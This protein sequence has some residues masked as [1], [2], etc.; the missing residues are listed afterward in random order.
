M[1]GISSFTSRPIRHHV[2][3]IEA[4]GL[5][6][7]ASKGWKGYSHNIVTFSH[8]FTKPHII[9][10]GEIHPGCF[11]SQQALFRSMLVLWMQI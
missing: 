11:A 10:Y 2:Q 9:Q 6:I 7:R 8:D 3:R 4:D 1:P 5:E